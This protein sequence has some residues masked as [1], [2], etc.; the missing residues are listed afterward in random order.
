MATTLERSTTGIKT[1]PAIIDCDIHNEL[2][3]DRAV[4]ATTSRVLP[5]FDDRSGPLFAG[6]ALLACLAAVASVLE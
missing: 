2:D 3:S 1:R 4:L 6:G 5:P